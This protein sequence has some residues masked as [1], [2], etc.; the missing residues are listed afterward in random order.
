MNQ[1]KRKKGKDKE[2]IINY[3]DLNNLSKEITIN[4]GT[5]LLNKLILKKIFFIIF[6]NKYTTI[7]EKNI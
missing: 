4:N 7:F 6:L 5:M 2:T 3:N 1:R